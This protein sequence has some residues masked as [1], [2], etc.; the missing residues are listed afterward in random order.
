MDIDSSMYVDKAIVSQILFC[1]IAFVM[2]LRTEYIN[3]LMIGLSVYVHP[4]LL[5]VD[6]M[7]HSI[8]DSYSSCVAVY[9]L[10]KIDIN[11]QT[12]QRQSKDKCP[13]LFFKPE[14]YTMKIPL[15]NY[16]LN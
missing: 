12:D 3:S 10:S 5:R 9:F 13:F 7:F 2:L 16:S 15:K 4:A 6:D 1:S 14:K 8:S 11:H